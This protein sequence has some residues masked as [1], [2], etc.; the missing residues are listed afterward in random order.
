VLENW[1]LSGIQLCVVV[2]PANNRPLS[3]VVVE[4]DA[5]QLAG[6]VN[7]VVNEPTDILGEFTFSCAFDSGTCC[8]ILALMMHAKL[9]LRHGSDRVEQSKS[10]YERR[11]EKCTC[12]RKCHGVCLVRTASCPSLVES[13][14][15]DN[16]TM[17]HA[18]L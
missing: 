3:K 7:V 18:V 9:Q 4:K 11:V 12:A 6:G 14:T 2:G 8:L 17:R 5:R 13:L 15:L 1:K 16:A 10:K